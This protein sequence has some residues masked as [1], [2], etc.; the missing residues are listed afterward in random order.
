MGRSVMSCRCVWRTT[1]SAVRTVWSVSL[2]Y[3]CVM[4][5][6]GPAAPAGVHWA[7]GYTSMTRASPSC[8]SSPSARVTRWPKSSSNSSLRRARP[9]RGGEDVPTAED[10]LRLLMCWTDVNTDTFLCPHQCFCCP[11]TPTEKGFQRHERG[12]VTWFIKST[13]S[14]AVDEGG[15]SRRKDWTQYFFP[16]IDIKNTHTSSH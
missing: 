2:S 14:V 6:R 1:A 11:L 7:H 4:S 8:A 12:H 15:S 5:R 16:Y 13:V 10:N 3:S 9:R